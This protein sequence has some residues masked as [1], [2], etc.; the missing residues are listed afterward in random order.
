MQHNIVDRP[1]WIKAR[2]ELLKQEKAFT[3]QRD[4]LSAARREMPW[5]KIEDAYAFDTSKG[6]K[7]LADLFD[8]KSQLLIY[9]FM[10]GADWEAGCKS[11]SFWADSFNGIDVHLAERDVTF[12]AISR[13][14]LDKLQAFRQRMGW[15]FNWV[16]SAPSTFS[17]DFQVSFDK[18]QFE[19]GDV[20]YNYKPMGFETDELQGISVFVSDD[21]GEVYHTY[22]TYGRGVDLMNSAYNYLDLVPK[23]RDEDDLDFTMSWLKLHDSY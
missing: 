21:D 16:S 3:E 2:H 1:E 20:T 4:R 10:Y 23:G 17:E 22:S 12:L 13:G 9:H 8:G 18:E 15:S 6:R 14:P 7:S 19:A 5:V 11:C